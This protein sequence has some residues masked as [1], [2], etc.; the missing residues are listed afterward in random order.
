[1][2]KAFFVCLF[3]KLQ[4]KILEHALFVSWG[5][6][7]QCNNNQSMSL[8]INNAFYQITEAS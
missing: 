6:I 8:K 7:V 2:T 5:F 4:N 1:M 3:F